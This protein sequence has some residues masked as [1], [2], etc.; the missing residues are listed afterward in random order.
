M[1]RIVYPE[2]AL[3]NSVQTRVVIKFSVETD[4]SIVDVQPL[5]MPVSP[6][7]QEFVRVMKL[8]P[9]WTPAKQDGVPV[10]IAMIFAADVD[11]QYRETDFEN[12]S[13]M[14][15]KTTVQDPSEQRSEAA[16]QDQEGR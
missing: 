4:G 14:R 12:S 7:T 2:D 3:G 9:A 15:F 10:R 5:Y 1:K 16:P 13:E 6:L 8:S 11:L